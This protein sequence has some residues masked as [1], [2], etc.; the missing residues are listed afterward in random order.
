MC[1]VQSGADRLA[2]GLAVGAAPVAGRL[3]PG[4]GFEYDGGDDHAAPLRIRQAD[5]AGLGHHTQ[6]GE[7][8]LHGA[9][10]DLD[11]AGDDDIV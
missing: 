11:A 7:G 10:L 9:G 3:L 2:Q 5:G 1:A 4:C 6:A 8:L